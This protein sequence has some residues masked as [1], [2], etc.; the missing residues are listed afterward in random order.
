MKEFTND[1]KQFTTIKVIE[2]GYIVSGGLGE[3]REYYCEDF[4]FLIEHLGRRLGILRP[5]EEV[6]ELKLRFLEGGES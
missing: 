3:S 1:C 4:L 5:S 6:E 2:N